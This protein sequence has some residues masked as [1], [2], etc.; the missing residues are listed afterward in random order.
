M[1]VSDI[2]MTGMDGISF[3]HAL[4]DA[5][6]NAGAQAAQAHR[7]NEKKAGAG[8][9]D[10]NVFRHP[11]PAPPR[12]NIVL[13]GADVDPSRGAEDAELALDL[14]D[15]QDT[16]GVLC[17]NK[18]SAV[19]VV[20][21]VI[22]PHVAFVERALAS[23][24]GLGEGFGGEGFRSETDGGPRGSDDERADW[25]P[26]PPVTRGTIPETD[27]F[28]QTETE[29]PFD[30]TETEPFDSGRLDVDSTMST[31]DANRLGE[32]GAAANLVARSG[33]SYGAARGRPFPDVSG[34]RDERTRN[35]CVSGT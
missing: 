3:F 29:P 1:V 11:S 17:Y 18:T 19:D 33:A 28:D 30:Q 5:N 27:P 24:R 34:L 6:L 35:E 13:T 31:D 32:S 15:L 4:F 2:F 16:Y 25:I 8:I 10:P 23:A 9:R 22:K 21:D 7:A 14:N 12:L 20:V 26:A